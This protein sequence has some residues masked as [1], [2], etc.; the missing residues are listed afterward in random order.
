MPMGRPPVPPFGKAVPPQLEKYI[1]KPV[2]EPIENPNVVQIE[3]PK[4]AKPEKS[5]EEVLNYVLNGILPG[6]EK[7]SNLFE[8]GLT[9]FDVM[10]VIT[11]CG[12]YGYQIDMADIFLTPTFEE[13]VAKMK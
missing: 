4:I 6:F 10:K 7:D 5:A 12:Q 9:S 8:Q 2:K 11:R 1:S 13:I 3:K